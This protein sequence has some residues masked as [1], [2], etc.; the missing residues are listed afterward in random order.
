MLVLKRLT[1]SVGRVGKR[2]QTDGLLDGGE[3][4]Y[5]A[6]RLGGDLKPEEQGGPGSRTVGYALTR[7]ARGQGLEASQG[8]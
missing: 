8:V 7:R 6:A 4:L 5:Q 2:R 1:G 3:K